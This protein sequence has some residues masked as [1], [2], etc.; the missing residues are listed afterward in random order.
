MKGC[1]GI[2]TDDF[3]TITGRQAT[4]LKTYMKKNYQK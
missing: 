3:R 2:V 1:L 4:D